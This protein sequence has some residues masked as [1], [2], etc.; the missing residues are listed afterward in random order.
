MDDESITVSYV[1]TD[2]LHGGE[3]AAEEMARRLEGKGDV[4]LLRY[5]AGSESTEQRERGIL[6]T[7]AEHPGIRVVSSNGIA[8]RRRVAL[9]KAQQVFNTFAG[10]SMGRVCDLRTHLHR[11]LGA[12]ETR[13]L[14]RRGRVCRLRS[15]PR[16]VKTMAEG[17]MQGIA[18]AGPR[19]NGL[20]RGQNDGPAPR[21]A[22]RSKG[23]SSR[24]YVATPE[25]MQDELIDKLLHR[26][27]RRVMPGVGHGRSSAD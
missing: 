20:P 18:P 16:L 7:L 27:V 11:V 23:G 25:N 14:D 5:A 9:D 13:G 12:L 10:G 26:S 19:E 8:A 21:G 17:K 3:L 22:S 4:I 6:S 15:H 2:N 1:A 24:E